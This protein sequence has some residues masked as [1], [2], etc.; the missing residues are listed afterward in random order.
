L[1][2]RVEDAGKPPAA[3]LYEYRPVTRLISM[4]VEL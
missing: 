3:G 2:K 4:D 1:I